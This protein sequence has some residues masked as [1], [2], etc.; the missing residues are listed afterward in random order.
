MEKYPE[1]EAELEL[2]QELDDRPADMEDEIF[3]L[4]ARGHVLSV[5]VEDDPEP[6]ETEEPTDVEY[7]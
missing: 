1:R 6:E 5:E 2:E 7:D 4:D 3:V